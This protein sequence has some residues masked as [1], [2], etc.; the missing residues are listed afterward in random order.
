MQTMPTQQTNQQSVASQPQATINPPQQQFSPSVTSKPTTMNNIK[1]K[2]TSLN[3]Y[4]KF[5][6]SVVSL[7]LLILSF[8]VLPQLILQ[9]SVITVLGVGELEVP[10]EKV[11]M[12][13]TISTV[14]TDSVATIN[15]ADILTNLLVESAKSVTGEGTQISKAFYQVQPIPQQNGYTYQVINAFSIETEQVTKTNELIKTLYRDGATSV[16]NVTFSTLDEDMTAQEARKLAVE[17]AKAQAKNI[18]KTAGKRVGRIVAIT[19]D[20]QPSASTVTNVNNENQNFNNVS[21]TKLVSISYE[22]W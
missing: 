17:D 12:I 7:I 4:Q 8:T 1:H 16:S 20:N 19:D 9:P 3:F 22:I 21:L 13:V 10:A 6:V 5:W 14:G 15:E 11:N 18:A 2:F